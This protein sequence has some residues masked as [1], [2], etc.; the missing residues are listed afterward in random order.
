MDIEIL[1]MKIKMLLCQDAILFRSKD[2][3]WERKK[4]IPNK[5]ESWIQD[6]IVLLPKKTIFFCFSMP[7]VTKLRKLYACSHP[8]CL[9]NIVK[10]GRVC[11][12][13]KSHFNTQS[14][15]YSLRLESTG[16]FF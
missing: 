5:L 15:F 9:F 4:I 7:E 3:D 16:I 2:L 13:L 10:V 14:G 8:S 11:C 1:V 12:Y 6:Y